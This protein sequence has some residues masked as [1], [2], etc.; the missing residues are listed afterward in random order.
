VTRLQLRTAAGETLACRLADG[1]AT[2]FL[3]LMGRRALPPDEGLLLAPGGSIHTLFMRFPLDVVFVGADG[4]ALGIR[5][6]LRPWRFARAPR[7]TRYV[8]ELTAGGQAAGGL[9]EG[10]QLE[11]E[12]RSWDT[13]RGR[14][15]WMIDS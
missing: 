8:L 5:R 10:S 7:G 1:F 2:R 13:L 9:E 4:T 6:R 14:R 12:G 11:L 15:L 3:G